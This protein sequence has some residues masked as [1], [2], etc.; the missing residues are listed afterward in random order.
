MADMYSRVR[1]LF[2]DT[3]LTYVGLMLDSYCICAMVDRQT[4]RNK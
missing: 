2:L 1:A 4:F 3:Y